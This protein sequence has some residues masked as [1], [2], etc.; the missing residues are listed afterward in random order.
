WRKLHIFCCVC[1]RS[2]TASG[3]PYCAIL[4]IQTEAVATG[5][6]LAHLASMR[7]VPA[8]LGTCVLA[9]CPGDGG[10]GDSP[11]YE[12]TRHAG[13]RSLAGATHATSRLLHVEQALRGPQDGLVQSRSEVDRVCTDHVYPVEPLSCQV[14]T[15]DGRR[16]DHAAAVN[17]LCQSV[18]PGRLVTRQ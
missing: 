14:P 10:V 18:H 4:Y 8:D 5:L 15:P 9:C 6:A 17:V 13:V 1:K 16:G 2:E 11:W 3:I 7:R 12:R